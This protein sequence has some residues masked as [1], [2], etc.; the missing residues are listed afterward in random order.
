MRGNT[1]E[2][3][4]VAAWQAGDQA[5]LAELY[6]RFAPALR[7]LC[8]RRLPDGADV[9]DVVHEAFLRAQRAVGSLDPAA[10]IWPWLATIA[11]RLCTDERRRHERRRRLEPAEPATAVEL[12]EQ[13]DARLR[14]SIMAEAIGR[15][16]PPHR[17]AVVLHHL[18]GWTYEDIARQQGRSL[19]AVRSDLLRARPKLRHRV[20]EVAQDR[21]QWPLPAAAP[22]GRRLRHA[23]GQARTSAQAYLAVFEVGAL[24]HSTGAAILLAAT[25]GGAFNGGNESR[26][27]G[28]IPAAPTA[29]S[30]RA[31]QAPAPELALPAPPRPSPTTP[32]PDPARS[33]WQ[34]RL[35]VDGPSRATVV[36]DDPRAD[37]EDHGDYITY[38][39]WTDLD[40]PVSDDYGL[41]VSG[42]VACNNAAKQAVCNGIRMVIPYLPPGAPFS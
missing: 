2:R 1:D 40:T 27:P 6:R 25:L 5:A 13:V 36:N 37:V 22:L 31:A 8:S 3:A 19:T 28:P 34:A 11:R 20:R 10:P 15:L 38:E 17:A 26:P 16:S 9:D 4:L 32:A 29:T 33:T 35:A 23:V 24:L 14:R 42:N 18:L 41:G 7:T 21:R 39:V 12:D 30:A